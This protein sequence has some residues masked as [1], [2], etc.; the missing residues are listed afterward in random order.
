MDKLNKNEVYKV[1]NNWLEENNTDLHAIIKD[2][3]VDIY[4]SLMNNKNNQSKS[5]DMQISMI[6]DIIYSKFKNEEERFIFQRYSD[7]KHLEYL[8]TFASRG[9]TQLLLD[10]LREKG[11]S[12]DVLNTHLI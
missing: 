8:D 11:I 6:D 12:V 5:R 1:I 3:I 9:E 2:R 7:V 4:D 10:T